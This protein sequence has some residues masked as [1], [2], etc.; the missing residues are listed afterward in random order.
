MAD[1]A[2]PPRGLNRRALLTGAAIG[3]AGAGAAAVGIGGTGATSKWLGL[4][5][6]VL[7]S[8]NIFGGFAVTAML[9]VSLRE[10]S[11]AGAEIRQFEPARKAL[12]QNAAFAGND[13]HR[14]EPCRVAPPDEARQRTMRIVLRHAVQIE[15][16][17][18][19]FR[20]ARD[21]SCPLALQYHRPGFWR[22][23]LWLPTGQSGF[24]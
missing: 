5:A 22:Q 7:A 11:E 12:A 15:P 6:V 3:A 17:L 8:V 2:K 10:S 24:L 9:A 23:R 16:R 20:P 21:P 1:D 19:L 18:D 13:E 4:L 14:P